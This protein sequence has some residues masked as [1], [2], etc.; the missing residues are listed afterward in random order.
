VGI[1]EGR[2]LL[3]LRWNGA[4]NVDTVRAS[5]ALNER[6]PLPTVNHVAEPLG[7]PATAAGGVPS[8]RKGSS[9]V[10]PS[11]RVVADRLRAS[12]HDGAPSIPQ[13]SRLVAMVGRLRVAA[14][15]TAFVLCAPPRVAEAAPILRV[16][17]PTLPGCPSSAAVL[18][19]ARAG[20]GRARRVDDVL[21]IA[22]VTP[23]EAEG[24]PWRL[25]IRVRTV[26][27]AGE[28]MLEAASCGALARAAGLL[29]SIAALRTQPPQTD[30]PIE[31]L[32]PA[33]D[34]V[35]EPGPLVA[36][37]ALATLPRMW[38]SHSNAN[39]GSFAANAG[40]GIDVGLL[41][42]VAVGP[43]VVLGYESGRENDGETAVW[44]VHGGFF[45]GFPQDK[46]RR[47]AL[48]ELG[49]T[50]SSLGASLDLC[51]RLPF[52][53]AALARTRACAG[54]TIDSV[55][56]T[57]LGGTSTFEA[58][59][60]A[61]MAFAG[62]GADW[63]LGRSLRVGVD[64]RVGASLMRPTF[65]VDSVAEGERVVHRTAPVR[66]QATVTFGVVF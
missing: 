18:E 21:A 13:C 47:A 45:S 22:D 54:A 52:P 64:G 29:M 5:C 36:P 51:R 31:E 44:S 10:R 16:E 28:R 25:R 23:P 46:V 8:G 38:S 27:G 62:V 57:G 53:R 37:L 19:G 55:H 7:T 48:G 59:R 20:I 49:G 58:R 39:S 61:A 63:D 11:C 1:V 15:A 14:S 34:R 26:H 60:V 9:G 65:V 3:L 30:H 2:E 66:G 33:P 41:P 56:A 40:I 43:S 6:V 50:F 17:W 35:E 12:S 32:A 4:S 24:S 42:S